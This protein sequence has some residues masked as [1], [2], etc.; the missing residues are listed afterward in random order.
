[1]MCLLSAWGHGAVEDDTVVEVP[2]VDDEAPEVEPLPD[3]LID[4]PAEG[5]EGVARGLRPVE[6]QHYVVADEHVVSQSR[7]FSVSGGD[8]LR[9]GA[10][11]SHADDVRQQFNKLLGIGEKWKYLVSVRLIGT[12]ADAPR[13]NPI[14]TAVRILGH[15][16]SLQIRIY[17][18]GGISIAELDKALVAT[19]LYEYALRS[20]RSDA[21]P[22]YLEMPPWL[23][24]GI[25]Q[26]LLWRQ[27]R[28]DRRYYE[29]LFNRGEMISPE[30]I[31][32]T[33]HPET[34]D[35]GS[36][37]LYEVSCGVL[38]MGLLQREGGADRLRNLLAEALTQEGNTRQIITAHFHE[39]GV[40]DNNFNK[41][42]ALAL[43]SLAMPQAMDVLTPLETE[44]QLAEALLVTGMDEDKRLP[45]TVNVTDVAELRKLPD[46]KAQARS[47]TD[48]LTE[49]SLRC[50]PGHR[51]IVMEYI[52]AIGEIL[53]GADEE[54]VAAILEPLENLRTAYK[55]AAIRGRDYLDWFEI[56]QLGGTGRGNFNSYMEAMRLLRKETPGPDTPISRYL[57]DIEA[58]NSIREGE[59]LPE[60]LRPK[61]AEKK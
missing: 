43:A 21:L 24:T 55:E 3:W 11:A 36:R 1:M 32:N 58:L 8:A 35:A 2:G 10:I 46:W 51:V 31:I 48:M 49:L 27:G 4:I 19:L 23:V 5:E 7:M 6:P 53:E 25:Q 39:M 52:R 22:D 17:A 61:T 29:K 41:W 45:Y 34:M 26:A 57:D 14:R 13:A 56:T 18:G 20:I 16:P 60:R 30:E 50:F 12:T 40:N 47:C 37:Q 38:M 33:E 54:K 44:K 59:E 9:M 28:V 42:W 15:E